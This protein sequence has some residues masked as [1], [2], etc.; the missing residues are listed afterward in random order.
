[1]WKNGRVDANGDL[2]TDVTPQGTLPADAGL[3]HGAS[4]GA[5]EYHYVVNTD[6]SLRAIGNADMWDLNPDAGHASL[7]GYDAADHP[8][9]V[10]MAG[11]FDVNEAGEIYDFGNLSGHY[12][13]GV[14]PTYNENDYTPLEQVARRAFAKFGLPSPLPDAWMPYWMK[15]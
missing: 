7:A 4:L 15:K 9:D 12:R 10:P 5:G 1:V 3:K 2:I 8:N 13:P 6:G 11:T 14:D